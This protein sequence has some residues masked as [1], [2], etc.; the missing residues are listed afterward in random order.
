LNP[1]E[2]SQALLLRQGHQLVAS[3]RLRPSFFKIQNL[4]RG[5]FAN[6]SFVGNPDCV[7][8][9]ASGKFFADF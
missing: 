8:P 1:E 9:D 7:L 2:S 3:K 4:L 6:I 5:N